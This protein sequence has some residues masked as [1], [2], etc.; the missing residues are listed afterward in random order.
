MIPKTQQNGNAELNDQRKRGFPYL[1]QN[2]SNRCLAALMTG[3]TL[4]SLQ[5]SRGALTQAQASDAF[6]DSIG[7]GVHLAYSSGPYG[8]FDTVVKPRLS[9]LGVRHLRDGIYT[10]SS[11]GS[12]T[13]FANKVLNLKQTLGISFTALYSGDS[14]AVVNASIQEMLPALVAVEGANESDLG[15]FNF[16]YNGGR[17]PG[18]LDGGNSTAGNGTRGYQQ[19]LYELVKNHANPAVRALP[20]IQAS[21][22]WGGNSPTLG[23][24]TAY[25][26]FGNMH[27]YTANADA[28]GSALSSW[29]I[30]YARN[31]TNTSKPLVCTESG[32][33]VNSVSAWAQARYYPR[34]LAEHWRTGV[35]R[36]FLYEL[37]D[38]EDNGVAHGGFGLCRA[39]GTKRES[40][41]AV[42]RMIQFFSDPGTPFT[43]GSLDYSLTGGA[44]TVRSF[45][46]Q[47]R[48]GDFYLVLWNDAKNYNLT[49]KSNIY[50]ADQ[51]VTLKIN[52]FVGS[53]EIY[54]PGLSS[55]PMQII[56]GSP[57][58]LSLSVPDHPVVVVLKAAQAPSLQPWNGRVISLDFAWSALMAPTEFAGYAYAN[59]WNS[60]TGKTGSALPLKDNSGATTTATASWNAYRSSN[61]ATTFV[62][63]DQKM[64][65]GYIS[66]DGQNN[67][68]NPT[69]T[70]TGIPHARYDVIVYGD[71]F[72]SAST[73]YT[74]GGQTLFTKDSDYF[75]YYVGGGSATDLGSA[76]PTAH[77]VRFRGITGGNF[78]V[79]GAGTN[80]KLATI[81]GIQIVEMTGTAPV[82]P[83]AF[84]AAS[85]GP[86]QVDLTWANV[87]DETGYLIELSSDGVNFN[88]VALLPADATSFSDTSRLGGISWTYRLRVL[89]GGS[90]DSGTMTAT[91]STPAAPLPPAAPAGFTLNAPVSPQVRLLWTDASS[92]E[93]SFEVDRS[94]DG[95][96]Y[97]TLA[98]LPAGSTSYTDLLVTP[99]TAYT[100]RLRA[101][102]A[103]SGQSAYVSG[104]VT[105]PQVGG[106][107]APT[108]LQS[109]VAFS[110]QITLTWVDNAPDETAY[111]ILRSINGTNYTQVASIAA[112]S[113]RYKDQNLAPLTAYHYRVVASNVGGDSTPAQTNAITGKL[114]RVIS[115]D[116]SDAVTG[117]FNTHTTS[118]MGNLVVAGFA[119]YPNWNNGKT[120]TP[121][122]D[123]VGA[124][125]TAL[126]TF[127]AKTEDTA[128]GTT[129]ATTGD[130]Q[131]LRGGIRNDWFPNGVGP[132]TRAS[133]KPVVAVTGIP[134]AKYNVF[135][136]IQT[137]GANSVHK[138][139]IGSQSRF[140]RSA[141]VNYNQNP[142]LKESTDTVD[143]GLATTEGNYVSFGNVVGGSFTLNSDISTAL[144]G[145]YHWVTVS[146][147]QI[148]EVNPNTPPTSVGDAITLN[149]GVPALVDVLAN[150]SDPDALPSPL[151]ISSVT[152]PVGGTASLESGQI[153][154]SP[155][156]GFH[157]TDSFSYTVTDGAATAVATVSVTVNNTALAGDLTG[158]GLTGVGIGVGSSGSSRVLSD[159]TWEVNG[160]GG[161]PA[162]VADSIWME[163]RTANGNFDLMVR[164]RDFTGQG[165]NP[166]AGLMLR[167]NAAAA[168]R[169]VYL[170]TS[171]LGT[172]YRH[173]IRSVPDGLLVETGVASPV[174]SYP[175]AWMLIRRTGDLLTLSVS[176][177]ATIY[178]Q[179]G[180]VT[181]VG[182]SN[183]LAVGV[184]STSGIPGTVARA[185]FSNFEI[186]PHATLSPV[187]TSH[188]LNQAVYAGQSAVMSVTATGSPSPGFQ[189]KLNSVDLPGATS[190]SYTSPAATNGDDGNSYT[191]VVGNTA[192][193]VTSDPAILSLRAPTLV[194][195]RV[196]HFSQTDLNDSAKE[197]SV[198][199]LNADPDK[200]GLSNLLEYATHSS[201][202]SFTSAN[203]V[204]PSTENNRL[205][206]QFTR[207]NPPTVEYQLEASPDLR[208]WS[209][210]ATLPAGATSWSGTGTAAETGAGATRIVKL[211]DVEPLGSTP[212]HFLRLRVNATPSTA[213][214]PG[215]PFQTP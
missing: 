5:P 68:T 152:V 7:V 19:D 34:I 160:A 13:A 27:A 48:N 185:V 178:T 99:L 171:M 182:L 136:Y 189:W 86:A 140:I 1:I 67:W 131:M 165:L 64:M 197:V 117:G 120:T 215:E 123:N 118:T 196:T 26:D 47:K 15:Q 61:T 192:G 112:N 132:A 4:L 57:R 77:F 125:T 11:A 54:E 170:S 169:G 83:A 127:T 105:T 3:L 51:A 177:D 97:F 144:S 110:S 184:F 111:K 58:T 164:V 141:T 146:G 69:V 93:D 91:V 186:I 12:R 84:L 62:G 85:S 175:D 24:L 49:T 63:P 163:Q 79:T 133:S 190:S 50:I 181:L 39:D 179:V 142:V 210:V 104:V 151:S 46:L 166:R 25:T 6:V 21:M 126:V 201:P 159:G 33:S 128:Y 36:T 14:M 183:A 205:V 208:E 148:V 41:E 18:L 143:T 88:P 43:A 157:G 9:E 130:G 129:T 145:N 149:E 195:W 72:G 16:S 207:L 92:N 44:S 168:S 76:T 17:F 176:D 194:E 209:R 81:A 35:K 8:Q 150:D 135:V 114:V 74:L 37:L 158:A 28:P 73:K 161:G 119:P 71:G 174:Y 200:D 55:L 87:T 75:D 167:E 202:I 31:I 121:L 66:N 188:P 214:I 53:A 122:V 78:T 102:S 109:T 156:P 95:T 42:K 22:G 173:G 106:P 116:W 98:I 56:K 107:P 30:P 191:V 147:I 206:L 60:W 101:V 193:S 211:T 137:P 80:K 40:F 138:F 187:I 162:G 65:R 103:L 199:G 139:I 212:N 23:D 100:Y 203:P 198:W 180:Q 213:G 2:P 38:A 204:V 134:Y 70:V 45:L 59:N 32:Y 96:T 52:S 155:R 90:G 94:S 172:Q 10:N 29:H 89:G 108:F 154:Y 153:R 20:V 113:V 124:T 82:L 115:I